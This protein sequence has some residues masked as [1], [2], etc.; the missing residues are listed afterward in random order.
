MVIVPT[1]LIP[2]NGKKLES[3][4]FELAHLNALE[5]AFIEWLEEYNYFCNSLVDRIVPGQP[6][7]A[8]QA[9]IE[10]E[11]GYTDQLMTMSEV[12][13][14]WAIEGADHIKNKLSF[15]RAD[16]GVVIAPDINLFRELKLRLLNGTHT[17]SSGL[18]VLAGCQTVKLAMDDDYL[19]TYIADLMQN[20]LA[21]S[22]PFEVDLSVARDFGTKVLDRFRNP[23]IKH[24]WISITVQYSS[25]MKM[26][27]IPI[28]LTHYR[29]SQKPPELFAFGFAA[30]LLFMRPVKH[31]EEKYFGEW[32]GTE[33]PIQDDMADVFYKRT[34][35]LNPEAFVETTLKDNAFWGEDLAALPGFHECVQK[36]Y[37]LIGSSGIRDALAAL[38]SKKEFV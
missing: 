29:A 1:E 37:N 16:E 18:A 20:E 14:L 32:N 15:A 4:V 35:S 21:P 28:L 33:Y 19:S 17:L 34:Q 8:L 36:C 7:P 10:T 13:R 23:H 31:V 5:E 38:Q 26:R 2:D 11:F 24:N 9:S 3:I 22:I 12:Y 27:N 25:K 30:Y 6:D